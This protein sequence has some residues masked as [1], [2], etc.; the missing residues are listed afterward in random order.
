M[1]SEIAIVALSHLGMLAVGFVI[2]ALLATSR[3]AVA[4]P[5]SSDAEHA[6][7]ARELRSVLRNVKHE[8]KT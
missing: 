4:R 5:S 3:R 6:E 1:E 8:R 7:L 2:G